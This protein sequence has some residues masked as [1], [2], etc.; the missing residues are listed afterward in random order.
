MYFAPG[1]TNLE[2]RQVGLRHPPDRR[3][4]GFM[5]NQ[6]PTIALRPT[7]VLLSLLFALVSTSTNA[8][9]PNGGDAPDSFEDAWP[10]NPET[11]YAGT[12]ETQ[13]SSNAGSSG[14]FSWATLAGLLSLGLRRGSPRVMRGQLRRHAPHSTGGAYAM[15][16]A[17]GRARAG[18]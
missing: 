6:I 13:N 1:G 9:P 15:Q 4:K 2:S 18:G 16:V 8:D 12:F 10:I 14:S 17:Y 5:N 11:N 7:K 3:T